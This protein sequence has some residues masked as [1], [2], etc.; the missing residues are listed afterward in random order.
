M[1]LICW[2]NVVAKIVNV[3]CLLHQ[4]QRMDMLV[5]GWLAVAMGYMTSTHICNC[6][7]VFSEIHPQ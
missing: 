6:D 1:T 7:K 4:Q 3:K 5:G 2:R